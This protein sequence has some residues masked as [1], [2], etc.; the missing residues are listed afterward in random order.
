MND[1]LEELLSRY[2]K[3]DEMGPM[4]PLARSDEQLIIDLC[5]NLEDI[6]KTRNEPF[7]VEAFQLTVRRAFLALRKG[8]TTVG[9]EPDGTADT[10][11]GEA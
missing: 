1:L 11:R 4:N 3:E 10:L 7:P 8:E 5:A 9:T 2:K 6:L